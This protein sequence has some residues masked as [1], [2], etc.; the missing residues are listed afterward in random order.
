M[1]I[2]ELLETLDFS[3]QI[4]KISLL[5]CEQS[6]QSLSLSKYSASVA[7]HRFKSFK[8]HCVPDLENTTTATYG[9]TLISW[10]AQGNTSHVI[11]VSIVRVSPG[12]LCWSVCVG[13]DKEMRLSLADVCTHGN[14][15]RLRRRSD[16]KGN[17]QEMQRR[18]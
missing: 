16:I 3:I 5:N 8:L 2:Y 18:E 17:T 11:I 9:T 15:Q 6:G 7:L 14:T 12:R 10:Q 13:G 1:V 4:T